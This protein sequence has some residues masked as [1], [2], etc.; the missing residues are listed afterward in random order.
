MNKKGF[1]ISVILYVIVFLIIAIFYVLLGIVKA[2]YN[3]NNDLKNDITTTLNGTEYIYGKLLNDKA[4]NI[5]RINPNEGSVLFDGNIVSDEIVVIRYVD[6]TVTIPDP[7]RE[8]FNNNLNTYTLTY[9]TNGGSA[10]PSSQTGTSTRMTSYSFNTW[11]KSG[12]CGTLSNRVYTF[13][14]SY[15]TTCTLTASWSLD[16]NPIIYPTVPVAAAPTKYANIFNGWKSSVTSD[17]HRYQPGESYTLSSNVTL[18]AQW[19]PVNAGHIG[20]SNSAINECSD[21]QCAIDKIKILLD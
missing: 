2:R 5:L 17:T 9:N 3:V 16:T 21:V 20:Y 11:S 14:T 1:A 6:D 12:N 10:A 7:T 19:I 13:P 4:V 18:T 8:S 15:G